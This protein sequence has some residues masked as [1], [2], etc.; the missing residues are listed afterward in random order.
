MRLPAR[1]PSSHEPAKSA[2]ALQFRDMEENSNS[3]AWGV[4]GIVGGLIA[5]ILSILTMTGHGLHL[6]KRW[7]PKGAEG[8]EGPLST[9]LLRFPQGMQ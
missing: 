8:H 1:S 5:I 9:A 4:V 2:L 6:L 3:R 7:H